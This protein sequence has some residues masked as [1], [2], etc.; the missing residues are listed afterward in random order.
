MEFCHEQ[1]YRHENSFITELLKNGTSRAK[2]NA[3]DGDCYDY[4]KCIIICL[5]TFQWLVGSQ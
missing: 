2:D 1:T 5:V 3:H 4:V